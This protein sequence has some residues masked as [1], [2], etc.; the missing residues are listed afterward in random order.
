MIYLIN[1]A[2]STFDSGVSDVKDRNIGLTEE[3]KIHARNLTF[4]F[5]ILVLSPMKRAIETYSYSG[6]KVGSVLMSELFREHVRTPN[7]LFE[8]E[9]FVYET[10]ED[11]VERV[12]AAAEFLKKIDLPN[13]NIGV[14]THDEFIQKFTEV[15][16]GNSVSLANCGY[17]FIQR[18]N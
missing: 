12:R 11:L 3:G 18:L 8:F 9:D 2:Q 10:E 5:N 13:I 14:I 7:N 15:T 6:I 16:Q 1:H 17:H 4:S